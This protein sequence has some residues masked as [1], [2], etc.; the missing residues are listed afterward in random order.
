MLMFTIPEEGSSQL[1]GTRGKDKQDEQ[2]EVAEQSAG[3]TT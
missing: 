2:E 3:D 1:T